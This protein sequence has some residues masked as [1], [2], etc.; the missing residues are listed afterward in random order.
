[1]NIEAIK[2]AAFMLN[3]VGNESRIDLINILIDCVEMPVWQ[4]QILTNLEQTTCSRHLALLRRVK[5][6]KTRRKGKEIYYRLNRVR[7]H[8]IIVFAKKIS[9]DKNRN[10]PWNQNRSRYLR[11]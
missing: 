7:L 2:K 11:S 5:C 4:L 6:V 9:Y 3:V 10:R 8:E 1:M